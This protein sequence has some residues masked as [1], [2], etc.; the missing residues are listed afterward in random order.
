MGRTDDMVGLPELLTAAGCHQPAKPWHSLR[1]TFGSHF[2]M[3]GGNVVTLQR[4]LG[5]ATLQQT[6]KY[7]HLAPDFCV[8]E[9]ARMS[10]AVTIAGVTPITAAQMAT[11]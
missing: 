11:A 10:F 6:M 3:A 5:H 9:M 2:I 4:L 8:A 7:V 1:D